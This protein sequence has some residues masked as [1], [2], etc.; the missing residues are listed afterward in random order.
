MLFFMCFFFIYQYLALNNSHANSFSFEKI[1]KYSI[2]SLI[3]M[4]AQY[5][6]I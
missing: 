6:H 5:I 2:A 4:H 3:N 1:S